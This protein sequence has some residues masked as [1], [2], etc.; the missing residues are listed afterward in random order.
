MSL[1]LFMSGL[2]NYG[3][4][5]VVSF[6]LTGDLVILFASVRVSI[7]SRSLKCECNN[8]MRPIMKFVFKLICNSNI[9]MLSEGLIPSLNRSKI[10]AIKV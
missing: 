6:A 1:R 5:C 7:D 4:P 9:F 10:E 3:E 2:L 8:G